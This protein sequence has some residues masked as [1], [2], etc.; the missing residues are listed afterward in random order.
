[1]I[2]QLCPPFPSVP[3]E[4]LTE[5]FRTSARNK[6]SQ[7]PDNLANVQEPGEG[8]NGDAYIDIRQPH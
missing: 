6:R 1:M 4:V 2:N 5:A 7:E 8:V 3:L